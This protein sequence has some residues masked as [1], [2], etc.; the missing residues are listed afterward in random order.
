MSENWSLGE[1][2]FNLEKAR[3][4]EGLFTLGSGYMHV[5]GSLEEHLANAPQNLSYMRRPANVTAEAF[6]YMPVKWGV[7]VP[8]IYGLH[9]LMGKELAN[10]PSFLSLTPSIAGEKLDMQQGR[11]EN[12]RRILHFKTAA[13]TRSF[14]WQTKQGAEIQVR[15]ERFISAARPHLCVQR[16]TLMSDQDVDCDLRAGIDTDVRTSGYDHFTASLFQR[17]AL[18]Q[19]NCIV[20]LDAGDVVSQRACLLLEGASWNYEASERRADLTTTVH[21]TANTPITIE[22]RTAMTTSIDPE[23]PPL[24]ALLS[25][26]LDYAA[27]FQ[28]HAGVWRERWENADVSVEGDGESQLAL[29]LALYHLMRAH[30]NDSRFAIDP[31]AYAGDAYRGLYFWDTEMY[32]LPFFLYTDPERGQM[33]TDFRINTLKGAEFNAAEYGYSGARYPWE[34]DTDGIDQ[35][36][37]WQYRDHEV[38]V[39]ADVV[40]GMIHYARAMNNP[41]YLQTHAR[42]VFLKTAEYWLER[43]DWRDGIDAPGLL[44]VMGPDEYAP[45]TNNNAYTNRLVSLALEAAAALADDPIFG[46]KCAGVAQALP[47]LKRSDGLVLQ[48]EEFEALADIDIGA[49]WKDWDKPFAAQVSQ[50]RLYRSKCLKQADVLL[51]MALFP[52]EFSDSEVALAWDYYLPYTTHDSSLSPGVHALVALRL[53]MTGEAWSFWKRSYGIDLHGGAE[54]GLHIAANGMLWQIAVFGFGGL[55]SAMYAET[56]TLSPT[57][58]AQWKRLAFPVIWKGQR[59]FI[60]M[61]ASE[62]KINNRSSKALPVSVHGQAAIIPPGSSMAFQIGR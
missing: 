19:I 57:L 4:N 54:E 35:C 21:L 18:N 49:L 16:L 43:V 1:A 33:L 50:E 20:T 22:K 40:Y 55:H 48:C 10:L 8:G 51:L 47:I 2:E 27:L 24:V 32:L 25:L 23:T 62:V 56:L 45:I 60:E 26:D 7:F 61:T 3:A 38:H 59:A 12:Y 36:P 14:N 5:R 39:T 44:G 58:P 6:P 15:Y 41:E 37:N 28:E 52:H 34:G 42:E 9:P 13:L 17:E 30:P 46:A 29:R 53:G 31:K 11:I